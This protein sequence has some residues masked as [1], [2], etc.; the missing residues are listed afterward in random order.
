MGGR[1][2]GLLCNADRR[3]PGHRSLKC[4][5]N[6]C[7]VDPSSRLAIS[8]EL[9]DRRDSALPFAVPVYL[10]SRFIRSRTRPGV[11]VSVNVYK[12]RILPCYVVGIG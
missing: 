3:S 2:D 9:E 11:Q 10:G 7:I 1:E 4:W 6:G 12:Y 8:L 5:M